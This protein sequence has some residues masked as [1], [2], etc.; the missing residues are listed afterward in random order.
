V[1]TFAIATVRFV[2]VFRRS[3]GTVAIELDRYEARQLLDEIFSA[4]T[5]ANDVARAIVHVLDED[6]EDEGD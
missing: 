4:G 3:D 1:Q 6:E 5:L 2:N